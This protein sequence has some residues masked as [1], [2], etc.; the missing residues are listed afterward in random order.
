MVD[1]REAH[2]RDL[3]LVVEVGY[4]YRFFG[5]DA[6]AAARVLGIVA[7]RDRSFMTASVPAHRVRVHL[8]RLVDAGHK[9]GVVRQEEVGSD[10]S[11][12]KSFV[13]HLRGIYTR[14]TLL[15]DDGILPASPPPSTAS[16]PSS[17]APS[18][19]A[20]L[21]R[22]T[23]RIGMVALDVAGGRVVHDDFDA[24]DSSGAALETRLRHLRPVEVLLPPPTVLGADAERVLSAA[25]LGQLYA[26][27]PSSSR[28]RVERVPATHFRASTARE[29]GP[30][31]PPAAAAALAALAKHLSV[32][33]N[34]G[35]RV[36]DPLRVEFADFASSSCLKLDGAALRDLEL[37][38]TSAGAGA[39]PGA[40]R[41]SVFWAIDRTRTPFGRRRLEEWLRRRFRALRASE[42][43][44]TP[45]RS[46]PL[47]P[48][49]THSTESCGF[50]GGARRESPG[51]L[52]CPTSRA[53]CLDSASE[54]PARPPSSPCSAHFCARPKQCPR[55]APPQT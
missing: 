54:L 45:W 20:C 26:S 44:R 41:G 51:L 2:G 46:S 30:E 43:G 22:S 29:G 28:V 37:L 1:L 5:D 25:C 3:L 11:S 32:F 10:R 18:Y 38:E 24:K 34:L 33:R 31:L 36:L 17:A 39:G 15:E 52:R 35:P 4:R 12:R 50:S 53:R 16:P 6:V 19:L 14:A 8:R 48:G 47:A 21:F 55:R 9:V 7:H 27:S 40:A 13:R 49:R 42:S 23:G